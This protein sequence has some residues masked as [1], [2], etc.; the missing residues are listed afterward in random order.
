MVIELNGW[1]DLLAPERTRPSQNPRSVHA[2]HALKI[3]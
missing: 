1:M 3:P 2:L